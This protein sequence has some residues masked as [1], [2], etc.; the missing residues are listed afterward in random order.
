MNKIDLKD[1]KAGDVFSEISHLTYLGKEGTNYEFLHHGSQEKVKLSQRYVEELLSSGNIYSSEVEVGKEDKLWT[2]AQLDKAGNTTDRVGDVRVQGIRS[3]F[4]SIHSQTVMTVCFQKADK[5]LTTKQL[6]KLRKEQLDEAI[7]AIEAARRSKKGVANKAAE[8]IQHL[9]E[10]PISSI[11]A[12]E[13]RILTGYKVQFD[14]RDGK[15]QCMDMAINQLRPV[16]IN[17]IQWLIYKGV[18]YNVK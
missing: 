3:I 12:G 5:K 6:E 7:E 16:N 18:K 4:E 10:N 8:V 13:D 14:S 2:Q 11:L 15:Y 17:T 1:L 9:Q